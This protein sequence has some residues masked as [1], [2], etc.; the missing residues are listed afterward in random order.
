[1]AL[2]LFMAYTRIST[3]DPTLDARK[4]ALQASGARA[5]SEVASG[6]STDRTGLRGRSRHATG[7]RYARRCAAPPPRPFNAAPR[8][9]HPS[10]PIAASGSGASRSPST[11]LQPRGG[12]CCISSHPGPTSSASSSGER[13]REAL[14]AKKRRGEHVGRQ[15]ALNSSRLQAALE[16]RESGHGAARASLRSVPRPFIALSLQLRATTEE[17]RPDTPEQADWDLSP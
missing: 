9:D 15:P 11:R 17:H 14:A 8:R 1:M 10:S 7:R 12:S 5:F 16:M 2:S 13:T 6:A 3:G 4:G